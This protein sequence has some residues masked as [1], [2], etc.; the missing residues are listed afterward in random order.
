MSTFQKDVLL[1][2]VFLTTTT[3]TKTVFGTCD[4]LSSIGDVEVVRARLVWDVLHTAAAILVV[5]A[6]HFGL[7][8]TFHS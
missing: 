4:G 5:S 1:T 8:R 7:R 2:V 3:T 6:G